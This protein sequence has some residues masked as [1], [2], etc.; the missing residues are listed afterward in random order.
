M[1]HT[2]VW[3][4][5][6]VAC[7]TLSL[8]TLS[9]ALP[10]NLSGQRS[11]LASGAEFTIEDLLDVASARVLDLSADG[12]WLAIT[13]ASRRDRIGIDNY[14]YGDPTYVRPSVQ[15]LWVIDT[16][17][18]ESS[19]VFPGKRNVMRASW[20]PDGRRLAIVEARG[21][22]FNAWIWNRETEGVQEISLPSGRELAGQG[23]GGIEWTADGGALL[24]PL[25]PEGWRNEAQEEFARL[26]E[27]P[28]VVQSSE[29]PFLAW[30]ALRR[31][32]GIRSA[33][34]YGI[35]S[36][37]ISELI[38]TMALASQRITADRTH[39]VYDEDITEKTSYDVIFGRTSTV[40]AIPLDG[41]E[42][43]TVIESTEDIR[44]TWS[45][46]GRFFAY[47][48][49]GDV[50]LASIDDPEPRRLTGEEESK[51]EKE[52]EEAE[53]GE[54]DEKETRYSVSSVGPGGERV[55]ASSDKGLWII[56]ADGEEPYL[57]LPEDEDDDHA[58]RYRVIEW[59][60]DGEFFYLTYASRREWE[61]GLFRYDIDDR[62]MAELVRDNRLY[63]NFELSEDGSTFVFSAAPGNR[64][65]DLYTA[66]AGFR[67][68]RRLTTLNPDLERKQ[69]SRTELLP[70]LD[71]DGDSLYAVIYYPTDYQRGT[72]YPTV[73]IV[74][75]QFFD[76]R[77]NSTANVLTN[78][79]YLV[80]NP[81]VDLEIGYPGEAWVKGVT[82]AANKL[83]EMGLADPGRLGVHGT[84]YGGYATNLLITQTDRFKAA[85][86]ISGKVDM[87]S[88]YTDS[89]RLGVRNIHAPE[90]SQDRIGATL[91]EQPQ[92]YIAHS[93]IMY[94]DRIDTPLLLITGKQDHN[95]P[96]RTTMEMFYALR[97]LGKTVEW[98]NYIDGGHG[99]PTMSVEMV[100]DY[101]QRIID[102]YDK[103]LKATDEEDSET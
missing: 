34:R 70:Y 24:L 35:E 16:H 42:A 29:E 52:T 53:P 83:I 95:V 28:I 31:R 19:Q 63:S 30:E 60:P 81:S 50:F 96:A 57:F 36:G 98:V 69:L 38:P 79:G 80:V 33:V 14:R 18:A 61:R 59:S 8:L 45:E 77:F 102:W 7:L 20:S 54:E 58:P 4:V 23:A 41:G 25:R 99:M 84:S 62:R 15:E 56:E 55:V 44:A 64:P 17:S 3:R 26:T 12:R 22:T 73:F 75:E 94:A 5:V 72:A 11:E 27:G 37:A 86:N 47:S 10:G 74:Y 100:E 88:F 39:I 9:A 68:V 89:P 67:R 91:W 2:N 66:D 93:A 97:R 65:N 46:D 32:S 76:D 82:A 92:K 49:D 43:T 71:V 90:K 78:Q 6:P 21:E 87:I 103:Y 85:I 13:V 48:K 1:S 40:K 101:Y 51:E